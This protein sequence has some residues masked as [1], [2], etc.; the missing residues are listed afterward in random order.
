[1]NASLRPRALRSPLEEFNLCPHSLRDIA[2]V[3]GS[4]L[5]HLGVRAEPALM[6]EPNGSQ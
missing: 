5:K 1:M 4:S 3:P 2:L 6:W